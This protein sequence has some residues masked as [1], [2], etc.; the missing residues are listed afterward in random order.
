MAVGKFADFIP[1]NIAPKEA[2]RIG[3]Y[4]SKGTR[5]GS[6]GLQNLSF[7]N[8]GD[9]RYTFGAISD[10]HLQNS[11]GTVDFPRAL[12]YFKNT[13]KALFTCV[14]G[15]LTNSGTVT[16][17]EQ[18]LNSVNANSGGLPV[19]A[20]PGN[21]ET[22]GSLDI[23]IVISTYTGKPLYYSFT[24]GND[25]FIMVGIKGEVTLFADG[26]LQ[27]LYETLEENRNKRCFVFMHVFPGKEKT[28]TCGNAYGLYHNYC[29]GHATQ[30][31]VF[32][33]LMAHYKNVVFFHGHSHL[34]FEMQSNKCQYANYDESNGYRS[35]H[36]P[37]VT[38]IRQDANNDGSA[39]NYEAGSQGYAV[40]VY[41]NAVVLRGMDFAGDRIIPVAFYCLDTSLVTVPANSYSDSTGTITT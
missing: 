1:E 23:P 30:T 9:K 40:D 28:A 12:Q 34:K 37:S 32:E 10:V 13:E 7:P 38:V 11:T 15:D 8:L 39:D 41:D 26:E 35:V 36:I 6:F 25:V 31:V 22:Y 4:D 3:V 18:Y 21:H 14:C 2:V 20:I 24:Q 27:W 17:L 5:V 19:Y 16:Q 29:W 33:S